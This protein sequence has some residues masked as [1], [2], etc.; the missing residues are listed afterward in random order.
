MSQG[1]LA[2]IRVVEFAQALAMPMCGM[3]LGDLGAEVVK[4]EPPVGDQVRYLFRRK[5]ADSPYFA[6]INRNKRSICLDLAQPAVAPII[7]AL[8]SWADV[9]LVSLKPTD[10][11]RYG[12]DEE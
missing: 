8:A 5:Q 3:L 2:G 9:V 12:L 4:V 10:V 1:P 6:S 7:E 11:P